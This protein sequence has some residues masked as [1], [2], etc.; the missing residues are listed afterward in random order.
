MA[1]STWSNAGLAEDDRRHRRG[2]EDIV[3]PPLH[4]SQAGMSQ[5]S[6]HRWTRKSGFVEP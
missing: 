3:V 4:H 1:K 5:T 2:A 6:H